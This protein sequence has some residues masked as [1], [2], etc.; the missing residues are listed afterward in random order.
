MMIE[1][2]KRKVDQNKKSTISK[3][4]ATENIHV[5]HRKTKTASF[6]VATRELTLPIFKKELL[7]LIYKRANKEIKAGAAQFALAL[8][9][10]ASTKT[11]KI[12]GIEN[13]RKIF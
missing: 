8:T 13:I 1:V 9:I 6:N 11:I 10:I 5:V 12:I 7:I 2:T 4:L 3:L